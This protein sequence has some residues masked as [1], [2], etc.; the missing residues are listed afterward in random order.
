MNTEL[1][2][3]LVTLAGVLKDAELEHCRSQP[4][5]IRRPDGQAIEFLTRNT[6]RRSAGVAIIARF[7]RAAQKERGRGV[8]RWSGYCGSGCIS[9]GVVKTRR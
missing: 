7:P 3:A 5:G 9:L 1:I 6:Q 4:I 8:P 2:T